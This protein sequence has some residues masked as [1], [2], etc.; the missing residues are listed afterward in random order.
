MPGQRHPNKRKISAWVTEEE[1]K[2]LL[3]K[4]NNLG[5]SNLSELFHAIAHGRFAAADQM[6]SEK[7]DALKAT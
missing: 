2:L 3:E 6:Q 7:N 5:Y 4:A 1:K